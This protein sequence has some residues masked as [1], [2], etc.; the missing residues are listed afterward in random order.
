[1]LGDFELPLGHVGW[2][3]GVE[4]IGDAARHE[5]VQLQSS[6]AFLFLSLLTILIDAQRPEIRIDANEQIK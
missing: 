1:M 2:L 4:R 6:L 3:L 5:N